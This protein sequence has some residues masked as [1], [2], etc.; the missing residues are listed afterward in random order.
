MRIADVSLRIWYPPHDGVIIWKHFRVTGHLCGE[1]TAQRPVMW[2][3]DIFDLR[4]NKRLSK[5]LWG[6]WFET[7]SRPLWRYGD[8]YIGL[9][10]FGLCVCVLICHCLSVFFC[11]LWVTRIGYQ[12]LIVVPWWSKMWLLGVPWLTSHLLTSRDELPG[13]ILIKQAKWVAPTDICN[14][15]HHMHELQTTQ[16]K[17]VPCDLRPVHILYP[18][19]FQCF[20]E[21]LYPYLYK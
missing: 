19:L 5:P 11:F 15:G 7:P 16:H 4:L 2:C 21:T 12:L 3:F 17:T 8:A 13:N 20:W 1:F 14:F 10:L 9:D 18:I 6:W